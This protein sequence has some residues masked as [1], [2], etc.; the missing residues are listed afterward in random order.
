MKKETNFEINLFPVIS[1]LAVLISFLLLTAVWVHIGSLNV[2]QAVGQS[3]LRGNGDAPKSTLWLE[4]EAN[5]TITLKVRKNNNRVVSSQ[6]FRPS[7]DLFQ[8]VEIV[9]GQIKRKRP[10]LD[11]AF[12][13][14]SAKTPYGLVIRAL[15]VIKVNKIKEVGVSPLG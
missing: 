12:V 14:A 3:A 7:R 4:L 9:I 2:K 13:A 6:K 5:G 1:L 11:M 8:R 15:E 10:G